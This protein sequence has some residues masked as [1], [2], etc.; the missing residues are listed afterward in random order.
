ADPESHFVPPPP[1]PLPRVDLVTRLAWL[2]V[3]GGPL[4]LLLATAL[5]YDLGRSGAAVAVAAFVAGFVTLVARMKDR[6]PDDHDGDDGAV[7]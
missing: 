4:V 7:V 1:P 3:L 5:G 6:S 2:A